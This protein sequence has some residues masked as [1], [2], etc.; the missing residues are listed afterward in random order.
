MGLDSYRFSISWPRILPKGKLSGGVNKAGIKYYNNLINELLANGIKPFVTLFHWDVPQALD[1]EY[2]SFLSPKIATQ[3]GIIGITIA[4]HWFV[5]HSNTPE[6]KGAAKRSLDFLYGWFM[7]PVVYG[8]YPNSM[9]AIVGRRLPKFTKE[10]SAFIKGTYDFIGVNYYT[11]FYAINLPKSN[12]T[13]PSYTTDSLA[14]LTSDRNGV[15]IGPQAGSPWLHV[16]PK[17]FREV[18]LY[19]KFKYNNPVIYITENGD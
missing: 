10:E 18:L 19:T 2:G 15:L 17:G 1:T 7:D 13:N 8:Q 4:C 5:P 12:I 3:K 14:T 9:R 16:Y 11:T 6:D